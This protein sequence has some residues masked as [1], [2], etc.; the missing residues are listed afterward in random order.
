MVRPVFL[1][2]DPIRVFD[3]WKN[4]GWTDERSLID[5]YTNMFRMLRQ[6]PSPAISYLLYEHL[7]QEPQR[8]QTH[9]YTVGSAIFGD[10]A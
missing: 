6:A 4:V 2:R 1:I 5:C 8:G 3:S 10:D 9:L 7:I